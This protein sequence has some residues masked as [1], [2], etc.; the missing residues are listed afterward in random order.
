MPEHYERINITLPAEVLRAMDA[1]LNV[2][3]TRSGYIRMLIEADLVKEEVKPASQ[4][5]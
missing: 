4:E 5:R 2:S 1:S 3:Q